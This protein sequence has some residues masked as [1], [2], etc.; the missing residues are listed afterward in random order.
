MKFKNRASKYGFYFGKICITIGIFTI[1]VCLPIVC[2]DNSTSWF[3]IN[4][5]ALISMGIGF[6]A[7]WYGMYRTGGDAD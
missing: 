5:K 4:I 2:N 7:Y 6:L 3:P 1:L